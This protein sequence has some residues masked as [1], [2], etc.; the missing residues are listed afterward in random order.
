MKGFSW[1][2]MVGF[3]L[4]EDGSDA[5]WKMDWRGRAWRQAGRLLSESVER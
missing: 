5:V 4:R 1:N 2:D 3:V